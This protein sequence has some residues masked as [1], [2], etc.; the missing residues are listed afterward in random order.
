MCGV[1]ATRVFRRFFATLFVHHQIHVYI[2]WLSCLNAMLQNVCDQWTDHY[3]CLLRVHS[4]IIKKKQN[5]NTMSRLQPSRPGEH[6]L[7]TAQRVHINT[8]RGTGHKRS[9]CNKQSVF[10]RTDRTHPPHTSLSGHYIYT[11][12]HHILVTDINTRARTYGAKRPINCLHSIQ[13]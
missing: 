9:T 12:A 2:I 8:Q 1:Y 11:H 10:N 7:W 4:M 13:A 6:C 5:M 3:V